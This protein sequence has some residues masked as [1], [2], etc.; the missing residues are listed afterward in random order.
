MA[1]GYAVGGQARPV[2]HGVR[3]AMVNRVVYVPAHW[4]PVGAYRTVKVPTGEKVS[5]LFGGLT[6]A[7]RKE[8]RFVQ[9]GTSDG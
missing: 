3:T 8:R 7:T 9:T 5:G 6:D 4:A 1:V 2:G